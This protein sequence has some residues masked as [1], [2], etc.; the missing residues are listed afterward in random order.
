[1]QAESNAFEAVM[2]YHALPR[3]TPFGKRRRLTAMAAARRV[4]RRTDART[5]L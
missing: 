1:M 3:R 2:Y 5:W 4:E